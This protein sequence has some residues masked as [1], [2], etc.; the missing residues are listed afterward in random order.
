[1]TQSSVR[2]EVPAGEDTMSLTP[3]D[4][5][6]RAA[7]KDASDGDGGRRKG[8]RRRALRWSASVLAVV[9]LGTA[10]AGYLYYEHLN[11]NIKKDP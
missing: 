10:G 9:I 4:G 8:R 2:G 3:A 7:G 6:R 5:K 11:H 1:M